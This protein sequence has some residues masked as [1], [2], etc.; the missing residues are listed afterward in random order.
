MLAETNKKIDNMQTDLIQTRSDLNLTKTELTQSITD[1]TKSL[2]AYLK[3]G[4][5]E[6]VAPI[7][8]KQ[9]EFEEKSEACDAKTEKRIDHLEKALIEK[10]E[11]SDQKY[12]ARLAVI[13]KQL[14]S[15]SGKSFPSFAQAASALQGV[16]PSGH[17]PPPHPAAL[18]LPMFANTFAPPIYQQEHENLNDLGKIKDIVSNARCILGLGPITKDD[19]DNAD[20][21]DPEQ[22]LFSAAMEFLRREIGVKDDEV[23]ESDIIKVFPVAESHLQRVYVQFSSKDQAEVLV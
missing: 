21:I 8:K 11:M 23:K 10:Q 13:E 22:K 19:V 3:K 17:C 7:I 1:Q 6:A 12:E 16:P 4:I 2:D 5:E 9:D 15:D 18:P 20:G 14:V